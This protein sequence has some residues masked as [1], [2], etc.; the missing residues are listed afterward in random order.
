MLLQEETLNLI[1][2]YLINNM[3][4][5]KTVFDAIPDVTVQ[6]PIISNDLDSLPGD[7][8][9]EIDRKVRLWLKQRQ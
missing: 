2:L 4:G 3:H 9:K 1:Q 5:G 7:N 6:N 8:H